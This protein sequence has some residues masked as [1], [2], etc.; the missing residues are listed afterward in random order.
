MNV[1]FVRHG[2][3]TGNAGLPTNDLSSIELTEQGVA[4]ARSIALGWSESPDVIATSPY[5]R[6]KQTAAPSASRFPN[7]AVHVLPMEEFT[8]LEPSRW[9]G[10]SRSSRLP[11]IEAFWSTADPMYCDGPGA[12]S[13]STLL[14]R[15]QTTLGRLNV[16]PQESLVYAFSHGQFMQA[17]RLRLMH[18]TW[19]S[20]QLMEHFWTFD[21]DNPIPNCGLIYTTRSAKRIWKLLEPPTSGA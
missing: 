7:A 18:P 13:F 1:V 9:N 12:E 20:K 21:K 15:V 16:L 11:H 19:S 5:L 8:Y 4:Q 17:M 10:T 3:S 14:L 2:E 6:T